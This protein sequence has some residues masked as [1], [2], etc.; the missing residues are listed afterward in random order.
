MAYVICEPCI[1]VKATACLG[2]CPVA[3]IHPTEND[4]DFALTDQLYI[5][6]YSCINCGQCRTVCDI[7]AIYPD[8]SV[9]PEWTQYIQINA[10]HF[11]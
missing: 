2:V 9:P 8:D 10:D 7:G 6:P 1:G 11:R 5:D 3:A 4:P